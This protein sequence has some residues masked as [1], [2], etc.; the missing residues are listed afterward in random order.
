MVPRDSFLMFTLAVIVFR[1]LKKMWQPQLLITLWASTAC[2][3]RYIYVYMMYL[4]DSFKQEASKGLLATV[5]Y[6]FWPYIS[7]RTE[8]QS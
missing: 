6:G 7:L 5:A 3:R 4:E 8:S 2:Y 1:I